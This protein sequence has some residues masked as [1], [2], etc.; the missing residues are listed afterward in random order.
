MSAINDDT[1]AINHETR[2]DSSTQT[3]GGL[4]SVQIVGRGADCSL[5]LADDTVSHL[6][7][8]VTM[9]SAWVDVEDLD[10]SNGTWINGVEVSGTMPAP[11]GAWVQFG[12]VVRVVVMS[13]DGTYATLADPEWVQ[14][15]QAAQA[16]PTAVGASM[17]SQSQG[18]TSLY[19]WLL[20]AV[21]GVHLILVLAGLNWVVAMLCAIAA[22]TVLCYLDSRQD[23]RI[24]D[25]WFW[26]VIFVP[27]Y[28]YKRNKA[29]G[30]GQASFATYMTVWGFSFL[31]SLL[32]LGVNGVTVDTATAESGIRENL[33]ERGFA[34]R[35]TEVSCPEGNWDRG[36]TFICDISGSVATQAV[37][38]VQS[39][40]G[41][42]TWTYQ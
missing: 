35:Y 26:G 17:P 10:S 23:A 25:E 36:Q 19:V 38:T 2:L 40:D 30:V 41:Y 9:R 24:S 29:L 18:P 27:V 34:T 7:A 1:D 37:V 11:V 20:A 15:A 12:G 32:P 33:I 22:N 8:K 31:I 14:R 4:G 16:P 6:H 42:I 5:V 39:D 13:A 3:V 28:L 21:L